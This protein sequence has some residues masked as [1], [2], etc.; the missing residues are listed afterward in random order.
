MVWPIILVLRYPFWIWFETFLALV[1]LI[2]PL[3]CLIDYVFGCPHT[4]WCVAACNG[5]VH[6]FIGPLTTM[7]RIRPCVMLAAIAS[8]PSWISRWH[9]GLAV[10]LTRLKNDDDQ[11]KVIYLMSEFFIRIS[12]AL[13]LKPLYKNGHAGN[14]SCDGHITENCQRQIVAI[15]SKLLMLVLSVRLCQLSTLC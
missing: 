3:L 7:K 2:L 5:H 15:A 6:L 4:Y 8:T 9:Q 1:I 11:K 10:Q 14:S 12:F 13:M